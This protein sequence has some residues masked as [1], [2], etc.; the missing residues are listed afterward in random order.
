[1]NDP[2]GKNAA[3][4]QLAYT[5]GQP[6]ALFCYCA[7]HNVPYDPEIET[8]GWDDYRAQLKKKPHPADFAD[9]ETDIEVALRAGMD[10]DT[11]WVTDWGEGYTD[12]QYKRLDEL[13][14][15]MTA[16]LDDAG[17]IDAQQEDTAR[18][19]S[20]L[21]LEREM[22]IRRPI[23]DNIDMAAKLDKM[24]RD[25]LAD[26]NMRKKDIL[27]Q[28]AQRLD[29]FVDALRKSTNLGVDMT[30]E[31]VWREFD[32]W[33][34]KR[35]YPHTVDAAEHALLAV[36]KTMAKN[37]DLPEP[38]EL[39]SAQRFGAFAS[40]FADEPNENEREAYEYLGIAR[41]DGWDGNGGE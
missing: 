39:T 14:R 28:Q 22:L 10:E 13:F 38:Q 30:Q 5:L 25:N 29:G 8:D 4:E 20:R 12:A 37:D 16:Q 34:Q 41:E 31:D 27:P 2:T 17:G 36:L 40:E 33:R 35:K 3:F 32:R 9:G 19:C 7:V 1:M 21:A 6:V 15:I 18:H 11:R 26:C 23:K 24:I